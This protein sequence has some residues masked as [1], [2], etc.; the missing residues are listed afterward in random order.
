MWQNAQR[1]AMLPFVPPNERKI[2]RRGVGRHQPV[3]L[4]RPAGWIHH[5]QLGQ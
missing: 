5:A 3:C 4:H 2:L 1:A